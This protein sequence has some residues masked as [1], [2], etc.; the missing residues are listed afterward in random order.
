MIIGALLKVQNIKYGQFKS[1]KTI[2]RF[3]PFKT[4][5]SSATLTHRVL[6][7]EL[8]DLKIQTALIVSSKPL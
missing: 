1:F 6:P 7:S 3:A 8:Q 4:L 2:K 5:S